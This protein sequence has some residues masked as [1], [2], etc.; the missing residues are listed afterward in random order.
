MSGS[1][2]PSDEKTIRKAPFIIS[3]AAFHRATRLVCPVN[4]ANNE[5][6]MRCAARERIDL[7]GVRSLNEAAKYV[8]GRVEID[9]VLRELSC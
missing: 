9:S 1:V 5:E 7:I 4:F 8:E 6:T 2:S 3:R